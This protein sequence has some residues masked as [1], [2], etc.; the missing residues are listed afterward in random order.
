MTTRVTTDDFNALERRDLDVLA[1]WMATVRARTL[2]TPP[3]VHAA[4]LGEGYVVVEELPVDDD[5]RLIR[6][7]SGGW[8][9]ETRT[10]AAP[11]LPPLWPIGLAS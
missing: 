8:V 4:T 9:G 6:D 5:G 2:D 1:A 3:Y 7:G 10:Y 11:T